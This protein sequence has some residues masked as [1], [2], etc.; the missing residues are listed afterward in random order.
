MLIDL[1]KYGNDTLHTGLQTVAI[2]YTENIHEAKSKICTAVKSLPAICDVKNETTII[3]D[4][5]KTID[6]INVDN[7][8]IVKMPIFFTDNTFG[9]CEEV[10]LSTSMCNNVSQGPEKTCNSSTVNNTLKCY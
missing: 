8:E 9:I 1:Q 5:D 10:E 2:D 7:F 6:T 4:T 3:E